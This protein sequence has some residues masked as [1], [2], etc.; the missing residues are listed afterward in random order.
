MF[1]RMVRKI[2]PPVR[3][4]SRYEEFLFDNYRDVHYCRFT[5]GNGGSG[6]MH[7]GRDTQNAYM[8][9]DGGNGGNGGNI[10]LRANRSIPNLIKLKDSYF[11]KSGGNGGKDNRHGRNGDSLI[12]EVPVGQE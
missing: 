3:R 5:G 11:G 7:F 10:W 4:F 2:V 1:H 12:V 9:P 6:A 8:G